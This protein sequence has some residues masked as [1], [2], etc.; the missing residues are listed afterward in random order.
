MKV[1][2]VNPC[3]ENPRRRR[4]RRTRRRNNPAP[5]PRRRRRYRRRR[6]PSG[7]GRGGVMGMVKKGAMVSAGAILS[8]IVPEKLLKMDA[9][10]PKSQRAF[11]AL[12]TGFVLSTVAKKFLGGDLAMFLGLGAFS[13]GLNMLV[14]DKLPASLRVTGVAGFSG[15][16]AETIT[17]AEIDKE[18]S[19]LLLGTGAAG[20]G[21]EEIIDADYEDIEG[22]GTTFED[23]PAPG[24][25]W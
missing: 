12:A 22:L 15:L 14:E 16:G 24:A 20:L 23:E 7:L 18:M 2:A 21:D 6:N 4:R 5:N 11:A 8:R 13:T 19:E 3:E 9:T 25:Y 10:K 17:E 1:L